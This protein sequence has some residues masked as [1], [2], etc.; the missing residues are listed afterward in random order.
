MNDFSNTPS[1]I[2]N[3]VKSD[4]LTLNNLLTAFNE[5]SV[6]S[7]TDNAGKIL[8]VN[9]KFSLVSKYSEKELINQD[10]R[11]LNSGYH[12]PAFFKNLWTTIHSGDI[13][14]GEICNRAKDG[15]L[16]WV[17]TVI[18]PF[19]DNTN[20][21]YQYIAIATDITEQKNTARLKQFAYHDELTG[22]RNA[23]SLKIHFKECIRHGTVQEKAS[24]FI[25][26]NI[27]RLKQVNDGYGHF[28]GDLFLLELTKRFQEIIAKN[29]DLFRYDGKQFVILTTKQHYEVMIDA[30]LELFEQAFIIEHFQFYSTINIG[31]SFYEEHADTLD[32]LI[33]YADFLNAAYK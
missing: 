7:I 10:H 25:L 14:H 26:L 13:W 12:S 5:S 8:S 31:V 21:P 16:Y 11:L 4:Q 18:V 3:F 32:I 9:Q 17:K 19:M 28:I 30:I 33:K 15:H 20:T 2:L 24:V 1:S 27:T 23:R 29:G 6:V 22:L